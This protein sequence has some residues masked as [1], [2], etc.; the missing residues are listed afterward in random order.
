MI[1][2]ELQGGIG[3]QMFQ[4]AFGRQ[5]SVKQNAPLKVDLSFFEKKSDQYTP[6]K[7]ELGVFNIDAEIATQAEI[8]KFVGIYNNK[9]WRSVHSYFPFSPYYQLKESRFRYMPEI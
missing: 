2:V 6:R 1:L 3:N 8:R 7:Y 9:I 4:Y 5:L